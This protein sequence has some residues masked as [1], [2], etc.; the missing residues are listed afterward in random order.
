MCGIVGKVYRSADQRVDRELIERMKRGVAH[1]GPDGDATWIGTGAGFGFRR[2]AI[3]DLVTGDQPMFNEDKSLVIV[4]NGEIYNFMSLRGELEGL[5]H[6]FHSHS[7]TECIVHGYEQWGTRVVDR[8]RGM[9]AF[10][11]WNER[12]RSLFMARDRVGKKPLYWAHLREGSSDESI[13]FASEL[14]GLLADPQL[15]RRVDPRGLSEYLTYEYVPDP[16]TIMEGVRQIEP[17]HWMIWRDGKLQCERYWELQ[18]DPKWNIGLEEAVEQTREKIRESVRVRL[19]SDVPV[20]FFL[21]SGTDSSTVVS[22]AAR[23]VPGPIKT[24]SA[25]VKNE[26]YNEAPFTRHVAEYFGTDH[27]E[28]I[29]DEDPVGCLGEI[30]W[31]FDEPYGEMSAVPFYELQRFTAQYVKV[32]LTGDGGDE[33]FAGYSRYARFHAFDGAR[34]VPRVL[35][36]IAD[37]P[38]AAAARAMLYNTRL[39]RLAYVNHHSMLDDAHLFPHN[40]FIFHHAQKR[41]LLAPARRGVLGGPRGNPEDLMTAVLTADRPRELIDRKMRSDVVMNN[42]GV[43]FPKTDRLTM[44]FGTE[45]RCP[46]FDHELMGFVGRMPAEVKVGGGLKSLLHKVRKGVVP[47]E[48]E[49]RPKVG[50]GAPW[51]DWLSGR[52]RELGRELVLGDATR[53]RGFFDMRYAERLWD[54]H[55]QKRINNRHRLWTLV[56]FEAWC[57]TFM[58]RPDPLSGPVRFD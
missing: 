46:F 23:M 26:K 42:P 39:E 8:L 11:I 43:S 1:R 50:F 49:K 29:I 18:Y 56:M 4:Y 44:A 10:A 9:F 17:A 16:R 15:E 37:A 48:S 45:A 32:I 22:M 58:D 28:V 38:L 35:R 13:I 52:M 41:R 57:R 2:L 31:H 40:T 7:D 53:R 6:T 25:G 19:V 5:G 33:N 21:S 3:I 51:D 20:G 24:F 30:A 14:K 55:Q 27:H 34:R 12:D 36:A 47:P 54:D